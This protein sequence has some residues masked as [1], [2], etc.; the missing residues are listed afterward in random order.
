MTSSGSIGSGPA[1]AL[2]GRP[3]QIPWQTDKD[4]KDDKDKKR[5]RPSQ[6]D[7]SPS[8]PHK[9]TVALIPKTPTAMSARDDAAE[10]ARPG[11]AG[12]QTRRTAS[13][14]SALGKLTGGVPAPVIGEDRPAQIGS[15]LPSGSRH[16]FVTEGLTLAD[17]GIGAGA[18]S[19]SGTIS[20]HGNGHQENG[21]GPAGAPTVKS[22]RRISRR[23]SEDG[24]DP[25]QVDPMPQRGSSMG[26]LNVP[27]GPVDTNERR[28]FAVRNLAGGLFEISFDGARSRHALRQANEAIRFR[29][30]GY[31]GPYQW[32]SP[33]IVEWLI[34]D[35]RIGEEWALDL[36]T[37]Q[38]YIL[39]DQ[40]FVSAVPPNLVS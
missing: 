32:I 13:R 40:G 7:E 5:K 31:G 8:P 15:D 28:Y 35:A 19:G 22:A 29:M 39:N 6:L 27:G 20:S 9:P 30:M 3:I 23:V 33:Q 38:T 14:V 11:I 21:G 37:G 4:D 36:Q 26:S 12:G 1:M 24:R 10:N 16:S 25:G 34:R 18:S 17:D 2:G